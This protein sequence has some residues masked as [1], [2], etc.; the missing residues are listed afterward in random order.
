M[1]A[2]WVWTRVASTRR[3][4][5]QGR[6]PRSLRDL[7]PKTFDRDDFVKTTQVVPYVPHI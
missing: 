3:E 2:I 7:N 1:L 6:L 4:A 5:F